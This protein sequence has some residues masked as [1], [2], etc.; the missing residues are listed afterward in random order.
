MNFSGNA[1]EEFLFR[2]IEQKIIEASIE[3]IDFSD[4]SIS[5]YDFSCMKFNNV[6]FEKATLIDCIF[7]SS[8]FENV[9]FDLVTIEKC[10][11]ENVELINT[12]L[13]FKNPN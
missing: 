13:A 3:N 5:G 4:C 1:N 10:S 12:K 8:T 11:F 6:S 9:N 7:D 2:F